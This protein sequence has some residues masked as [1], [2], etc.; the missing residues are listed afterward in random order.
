MNRSE[1]EGAEK[2]RED[3]SGC[4]MLL[5][6]NNELSREIIGTLLKMRSMEVETTEDDQEAVDLHRSGGAGYF[7]AVLMDI[8]VPRTDGLEATRTTRA[9]ES[10]NT[11]RIPILTTM[12]NAFEKDKAKAY[13]A[14]MSNYLV[15]PLDVEVV[16]NELKKHL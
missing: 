6:D 1:K 5:A 4:R 9:V 16:L 14:G 13:E 11:D 7:F 15:K 3:F 12:A 10:E 2:E 8:H